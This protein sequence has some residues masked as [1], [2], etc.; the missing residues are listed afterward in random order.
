MYARV[1]VT[2]GYGSAAEERTAARLA[3]MSGLPGF[4]GAWAMRRLG[5]PG[6]VVVSLWTD[7]DGAEQVRQRLRTDGDHRD[8]VQLAHDGVYE[9]RH[10]GEGP[11]C[12]QEPGMGQ[13]MWFDGPRS[14]VQAAADE[15]SG[16]ERIWPAVR[17]T[18][19]L[20]RSLAL[21]ADD[22]SLVHVGLATGADVLD[23]VQR[24]VMA[25]ELLPGEDPAL[26]G[27]PDRIDIC[28]VVASRSAVPAGGQA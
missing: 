5:G 19:G 2:G 7:R 3:A 25:T 24:R 27:G 8:P 16:T 12:A 21:Q 6:G 14:E 4:C 11:A 17:D 20:V 15:R 26:L 23:T 18:P 10:D 13:V 22:R 9:V 28:T 1:Q